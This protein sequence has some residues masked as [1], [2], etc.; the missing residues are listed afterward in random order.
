M[1]AITEEQFNQFMNKISE[2][3]DNQQKTLSKIEDMIRLSGQSVEG[4]RGVS[5]EQF[6]RSRLETEYWSKSID[7]YKVTM[8][9]TKER[10]TS[11]MDRFLSGEG[12]LR[13]IAGSIKDSFAD[14][15]EKSPLGQIGL[16]ITEN[17]GITKKSEARKSLEADRAGR[18]QQQRA[19]GRISDEDLEWLIQYEHHIQKIREENELR[20]RDYR[21]KEV[22]TLARRLKLYDKEESAINHLNTL[23]SEPTT[24]FSDEVQAIEKD[25]KL[26]GQ[27]ILETRKQAENQLTGV[28]YINE[29]MAKYIE[30]SIK[31]NKEFLGNLKPEDEKDKSTINAIN[32]EIEK[33]T[34]LLSPSVQIGDKLDYLKEKGGGDKTLVDKFKEV[35]KDNLQLMEKMDERFES[36]PEF[37]KNALTPGSIY[38]NDIHTVKEL[39]GIK[40]ILQEGLGVQY[41][42]KTHNE[43]LSDPN[44]KSESMLSNIQINKKAQESLST[45]FKDG[46]GDKLDKIGKMAGASGD[47]GLIGNLINK[48]LGKGGGKLLG[49]GA[50]VAG[51][52]AIKGG[53]ALGKGAAG[54]GKTIGG[55]ILKGVGGKAALVAGAKIAAPVA[56]VA[57][58]AYSVHRTSKIAGEAWE[59]NKKVAESQQKVAEQSEKISDIYRKRA[60]DDSHLAETARA[61]IEQSMAEGMSEEEA[62]A[63]VMKSEEISMRDRKE[64]IA[65]AEKVGKKGFFQTATGW[66]QAGGMSPEELEREKLQ[67]AE[68]ERMMKQIREVSL[69]DETVNET[70]VNGK[71][72]S[73]RLE[74]I[75]R[76]YSYMDLEETNKIL[77]E[78]VH[79]T[80]GYYDNLN[81]TTIAQYN[82]TSVSPYE[83]GHIAHSLSPAPTI[84]NTF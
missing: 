36:L 41:D 10:R 53:A 5:M 1:S 70:I 55:A 74:H 84:M 67:L 57:A 35:N 45:A 65:K 28:N 66:Q 80:N 14:S 51:K 2:N 11:F 72:S 34:N 29:A 22:L 48:K 32:A 23:R 18:L 30:E 6:A 81:T 33:F 25:V 20:I 4:G 78:V 12:I 77:R 19:E 21:E 61:Q 8:D 69:K 40:G 73:E 31:E 54:L 43:S 27:M 59:A 26:Y 13:S 82:N 68:Q 44:P 42:M 37:T 17:L 79:S 38:T 71:D 83:G 15:I 47:Y 63:D 24:M 16:R 49:K 60:E 76:D 7:Y 39:Q 75:G 64:R 9:R 50:K 58:S 3:I 62:R 46:V 52:G 56:I